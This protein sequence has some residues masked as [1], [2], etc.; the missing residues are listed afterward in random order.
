MIYRRGGKPGGG[1]DKLHFI[2]CPGC[3]C[4]NRP[5][6]Q[7]CMYCQ[8]ELQGPAAAIK[9]HLY[10]YLNN[11]RAFLSF[12]PPAD[13][14]KGLLRSAFALLLAAVFIG[15]GVTFAF[16]GVRHGGYFNWTVCALLLFYG[17]A[18]L[19]NAWGGFFRK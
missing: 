7:K 8:A 18:A 14:V 1:T 3:G 12:Q 19:R 6:E 16:R 9:E 2:E 13:E 17:G 10:P 15:L 4:P 5:S 11:I